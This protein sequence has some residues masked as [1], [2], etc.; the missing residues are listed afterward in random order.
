M[1]GTNR[2]KGIFWSNQRIAW[3]KLN[4]KLE[5]NHI[6]TIEAFLVKTLG[7]DLFYQGKGFDI[8]LDK[9]FS[10]QSKI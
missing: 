10:F 8:S 5:S 3:R 6:D 1:N 4:F 9:I 2:L 7:K